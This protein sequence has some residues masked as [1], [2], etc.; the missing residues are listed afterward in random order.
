MDTECHSPDSS[1]PTCL[2]CGR[3]FTPRTTGG[4]PQRFDSAS[5][6]H[7]FGS[8]ARA[9]ACVLVDAHL[10]TVEVLKLTVTS[11]R[12]V[13]GPKIGGS[14]RNL[15]DHRAIPAFHIASTESP[16]PVVRGGQDADLGVA[17]AA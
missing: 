13:S 12:A 11:A 10:L 6:R 1:Q 8:A 3:A 5:C 4:S 7:A 15:G 2:W 14:R 17:D 16:T 9:W